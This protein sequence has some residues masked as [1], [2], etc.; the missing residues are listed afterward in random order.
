[1]THSG[2]GKAYG[3]PDALSRRL[4]QVLTLQR[5][6]A[7]QDAYGESVPS[8][9]DVDTAVRG[10]VRISGGSEFAQAGQ[11]IATITA[12]ITIRFRSDVTLTPQHRFVWQ[13][14]NFN[15]VATFDPDGFRKYLVCR[16][17]EDAG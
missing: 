11:Q 6:N 12:D 10:E 2:G 7:S 1:M 5:E 16:C 3:K 13:S 9:T 4:R 17:V 15:V 8:W 14:R